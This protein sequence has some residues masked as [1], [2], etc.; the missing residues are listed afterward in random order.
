MKKIL[1]ILTLT[2]LFLH[3]QTTAASAQ[4][5]R[6]G[7]G[8]GG[9]GSNALFTA[10]DSN[11]DGAIDAAELG[12]ATTSLKKL[13]K[14]ADGQ[15]TADEVS[16]S[17]ASGRGGMAPGAAT[18]GTTKPSAPPAAPMGGKGKGKGKGKGGHGMAPATD[19][20][21]TVNTLMQ[22]D[23][24]ADGKLAKDELPE[25]MQGIFEHGDADKDGFM[26]ADEIKAAAAAPSGGAGAV[27][28]RPR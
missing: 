23:K 25:R 24:N 17:G 6:P 21:E 28:G 15:I 3:L 8:F 7:G 20:T 12:N 19:P 27:G 9:G 16:P 22:F 26:S 10:V 11:G 4:G 5:R 13:D 1:S 2:V 14:N 18:P